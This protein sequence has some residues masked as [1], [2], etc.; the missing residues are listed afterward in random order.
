MEELLLW[1]LKAGRKF[2]KQLFVWDV[3]ECLQ[4]QSGVEN[5]TAQSEDGMEDNMADSRSLVDTIVQIN[6]S[7]HAIGKYEKVCM[8]VA[9]QQTTYKSMSFSL[10]LEP[11]GYSSLHWTQVRHQLLCHVVSSWR[12]WPLH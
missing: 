1:Q 9:W 4:Q 10:S 11:A 7:F 12:V 3:F 2:Q 6:S 8:Y 5:P